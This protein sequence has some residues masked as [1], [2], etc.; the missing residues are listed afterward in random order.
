[1]G[2]TEDPS[3]FLIFGD[4]FLSKTAQGELI[5]FLAGDD[6][7]TDIVSLDGTRE[8]I[9]EAIEKV[10]TFSLFSDKKGVSLL[11]IDI[12]YTAEEEKLLLEKAKKS[13][14]DGKMRVAAKHIVTLFSLKGLTFDDFKPAPAGT[15]K[16]IGI[17]NVAE[18]EWATSVVN[19]CL[20]SGIS[21]NTAGDPADA[22]EKALDKGF[23]PGNFLILTADKIDK[24]KALYKAIEAKGLVV[25]CAVPTGNTKYDKEVQAEILKQRAKEALAK[26]GKKIDTPGFNA[27]VG[28]LGFDLRGMTSA[29]EKLVSYIGDRDRITKTDVEAV[30]ERTKVDPIFE[31]TGAVQS[32]NLE[33]ALFYSRTLIAAEFAHLQLLGAITNQIR[34]LIIVKDFL[35]TPEAKAWHP[36]L[37]YNVFTASIMPAVVA[38]DKGLAEKAESWDKAESNETPETATPK[39]GS[40]KPAKSKKKKKAPATGL[41]IAPNPKSPYPVYLMFKNSAAYGKQ[42]LAHALSKLFDADT[43]FKTTGQN[44]TM[45]LEHT[46][47][48]ILK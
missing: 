41:A 18:R 44:P 2:R 29:I 19:Y 14:E 16:N 48:S 28:N 15:L 26:S 17:K 11:E 21:V 39:K 23:P 4:E 25:D 37:S 8:N 47:F 31:L 20:E 43:S 33:A 38:Y 30:L 1:M 27:I 7:S 6:D 46:L 9:F 42:E 24:R 5:A 36:N 35:E 22:L 3:V 40:K 45:I 34:R 32:K 12:F 13:F 10:S